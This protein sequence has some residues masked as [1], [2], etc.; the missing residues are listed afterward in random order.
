MYRKVGLTCFTVY[1]FKT[2]MKYKQLS[3][4]IT[5]IILTFL[6]SQ[7]TYANADLKTTK[8]TTLCRVWGLLK[9]YAPNSETKAY[10]RVDWDKQLLEDFSEIESINDSISL[11]IIVQKWIKK[12]GTYEVWKPKEILS[13][14]F[15]NFSLDFLNNCNLNVENQIY[16]RGLKWRKNKRKNYYVDFD[17]EGVPSFEKEKTYKNFAIPIEVSMS[18][19]SFYRLWNVLNIFYPYKN[20]MPITLDS[21]LVNYM[22]LFVTIHN[23]K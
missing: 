7:V 21:C 23:G 13:S 8:W 12:S 3:F 2:S 17:N 4:K 14:D 19:L 5:I 15:D 16:L 10:R 1:F 9:Y 20:I 18:V 11:N 6:M 22:P